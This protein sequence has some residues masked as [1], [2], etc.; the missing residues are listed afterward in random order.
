MLTPQPAYETAPDGAPFQFTALHNARGSTLLLMDWGATWLS[1]R[2]ALPDGQAREVLLGCQRAGQYPQQQAFLGATVGRYANRI[3]HARY[4]RQGQTVVL[5]PSQGVNQLHG[6]P[7]GFDK[8][9][10]QRVACDARS[11]TYRLDSPD[12]DQGYPGNL[13]VETRYTLSD[14]D[15][16]EIH[17]QAS[18]DRACPVCLTN[19][20][21]FNLDGETQT[22]ALAQRLQLNADRYLPVDETGIP[23]APLTAV[24]GSGMDFRQAK[25]LGQDLLKD[26]DQRR[27]KGYDHAYLL[28]ARCADGAYPAAVLS[29]ADQRV[30]LRLYTSAPA[31]QLYSGNFLAGVPDRRGGHYADY[32]GVALESAFLP[33]SPNHPEWPQPDCMLQPSETYRAFTRY[34]FT[35]R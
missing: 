11:V 31:L 16:V 4:T 7:Q 35:L 29:A 22:D 24:S 25:R 12:G 6:G 18:V 1:C 15:Q 34:Q 2:L 20:A 21:Y 10:W 8:R 33:D 14:D 27:T 13:R 26:A 19:H 28:Q 30:S 17:W 5:Q 3:A 32:A 9:R 23:C